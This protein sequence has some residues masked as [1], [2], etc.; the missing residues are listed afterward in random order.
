MGDVE[1][2]RKKK[3]K[4]KTPESFEVFSRRKKENCICSQCEIA[5]AETG[6]H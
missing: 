4:I 6:V 2:R 5:S 3:E 1:R